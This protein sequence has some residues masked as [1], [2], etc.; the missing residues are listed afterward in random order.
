MNKLQTVR[1]KIFEE[2]ND[3][4]TARQSSKPTQGIRTN[5]FTLIPMYV[6][7]TYHF[8]IVNVKLDTLSL[9]FPRSLPEDDL[10]AGRNILKRKQTVVNFTTYVHVVGFVTYS[11]KK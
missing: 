2:I 5:L 3:N 10:I 7:S 1:G 9:C 8:R 11:H 6:Q 4:N